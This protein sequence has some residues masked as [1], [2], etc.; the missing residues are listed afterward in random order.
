MF[1]ISEQSVVDL[2]SQDD[3]TDV[4][5]EAFEALS[6]H[7]ADCFP[8]V[9]EQLG[10]MDAVF[11]FKS[12]FD[13]SSN[14]LGVKAGGLWPGNM[15]RGIANHQSTV[16]LFDED[17]GAP[18]ALVRATYLTS[19]RTAS[20]CA[21][22]VR[23]LAR[24]NARI[25]GII[26]AGG[27]GLFLLRAVLQERKFE[28]VLIHD[29]DVAKSARLAEA[30]SSLSNHFEVST[31]SAEEVG[32]DSDVIVT[33][34]PSRSPVLKESWIKDGVHIACMGADTVGKQEL[35]SSLVARAKPFGDVQ[36]QSVTLG[37]FQHAFA[38]G[39][40]DK[41]DIVSIGSVMTGED[42]GRVSDTD[43]TIFDSTGIALQDLASA[44]LALDCALAADSAQV[45]E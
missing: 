38:E 5:S 44:K 8:I 7:R 6:R 29:R 33:A 26:G 45:L 13:K 37:E 42:P 32:R 20:A 35:E 23:H 10:Y 36:E 28:K 31:V 15:D 25:L 40:V 3:V 41:S 19:L 14:V 1:Y 21:L 39:I 34:T 30:V 27:Q 2:V 18:K 43:I 16:V 17:S 11:G 9:R 22:S 24:E 12:G 4:V